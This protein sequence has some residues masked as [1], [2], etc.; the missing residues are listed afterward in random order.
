MNDE[1]LLCFCPYVGVV[2]LRPRTRI[3]P[4]YSRMIPLRGRNMAATYNRIY[5]LDLTK[6]RVDP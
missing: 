6:Q 1:R 3:D 4:I 5:E 2:L